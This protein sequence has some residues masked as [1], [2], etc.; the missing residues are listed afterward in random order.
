MSANDELHKY[1]DKLLGE[2][3]PSGKEDVALELNPPV[4][5]ADKTGEGVIIGYMCKTD[6]DHEIGC[7]PGGVPVYE[8]VEGLERARSCVY[9]CG[10]VEVEIRL[11]GVVQN[12]SISRS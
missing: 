5:Y 8:S 12:P 1:L 10:I 7:A 11:R 9:E 2:E 6:F 4:P 3:I